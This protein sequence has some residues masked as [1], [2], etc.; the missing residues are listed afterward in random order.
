MLNQD[1]FWQHNKAVLLFALVAL[2]M[3][4]WFPIMRGY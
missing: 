1:N 3:S 2:T 4:L